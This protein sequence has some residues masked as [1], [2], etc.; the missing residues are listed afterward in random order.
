[1]SSSSITDPGF[2]RE[3]LSSR[4]VPQLLARPIKRLS[5]WAAIVLP[6]MHL[7]LLA[8]GLDSTSMIT[9]FVALVALNVC[10]LFVGHQYGRE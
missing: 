6:F 1:M 9:A 4:S 8:V 7:S 5:F 10:A 3:T 2:L